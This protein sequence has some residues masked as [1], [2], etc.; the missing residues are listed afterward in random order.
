MAAFRAAER[1]DMAAT[2]GEAQA[3]ATV[4][5]MRERLEKLKVLQVSYA[6]TRAATPERLPESIAYINA[7]SLS[8]RECGRIHRLS[9]RN[10]LSNGPTKY[11]NCPDFIHHLGTVILTPHHHVLVYIAAMRK[12]ELR[13]EMPEAKAIAKEQGLLGKL[14]AFTLGIH[15]DGW[16]IRRSQRGQGDSVF[17][18]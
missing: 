16:V 14:V 4:A 9:L 3:D 7:E 18:R 6:I 15:N 10:R 13:E 12:G 11:L 17:P 5:R 2:Y 1:K 8:R